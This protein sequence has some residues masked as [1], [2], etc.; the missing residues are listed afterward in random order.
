MT[1]EQF[2]NWLKVIPYLEDCT[3]EKETEKEAE[4]ERSEKM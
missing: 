3:E 1:F 4:N 2:E